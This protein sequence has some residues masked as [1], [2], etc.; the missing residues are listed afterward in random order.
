MR[1]IIGEED[2]FVKYLKPEMDIVEFDESVLTTFDDVTASG[3][4][5]DNTEG[6]DTVKYPSF[7]G[8]SN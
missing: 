2:I 6:D 1:N 7:P 5:F 8:G 3:G 4:E